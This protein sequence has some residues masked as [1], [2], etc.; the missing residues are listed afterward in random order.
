MP[1]PEAD[2]INTPFTQLIR[3]Y[4][5]Q[6]FRI[7]DSIGPN[8]WNRLI[9]G[10][11]PPT[12]PVA[13]ALADA[14]FHRNGSQTAEEKEAEVEFLSAALDDISFLDL[15]RDHAYHQG[16][17]TSTRNLAKY[18]GVTESTMRSIVDGIPLQRHSIAKTLSE[19]LE[20]PDSYQRRFFERAGFYVDDQHVMDHLQAQAIS[21]PKALR[22]LLQIRD[23]T[24]KELAPSL[25]VPYTSL[26]AWTQ[27]TQG[28]AMPS[29]KV[30][31]L[32]SLLDLAPD[33][34]EIFCEAGGCFMDSRHIAKRLREGAISIGQATHGLMTLKHDSI[35]EFC[36]ATGKDPDTVSLWCKGS[37]TREGVLYLTGD[38]HLND[39]DKKLFLEK[40]GF[41]LNAA[42]IKEK[43]AGSDRHDFL[44]N[45]A[46]STYG[47][48][49]ED[50]GVDT[51]TLSN[52][53]TFKHTPK[54]STLVQEF[55]AIENHAPEFKECWEVYKK[56]CSRF[57]GHGSVGHRADVFFEQMDA[58]YAWQGTS[59]PPLSG[60]NGH[61]ARARQSSGKSV[62]VKHFT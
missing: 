23:K 37:I 35:R 9:L 51:A 62:A 33:H 31:K 16:Q 47:L 11:Q 57:L 32:A 2:E 55:R 28:R 50:L 10:K 25:S 38:A 45:A 52:E 59:P 3:H 39:E 49:D 29:S 20:I 34:S 61:L 27:E 30:R 7:P 12:F 36:D 19:K 1:N 54:I 13:R 56:V 14:W 4:E 40:A 8:T 60:G 44:I 48:R 46:K 26:A 22:S 53:R 58:E 24:A 17:V 21:F 41:F 42:H 15:L 6:D 43:F 18:Y 5:S